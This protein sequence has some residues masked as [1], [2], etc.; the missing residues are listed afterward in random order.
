MTFWVDTES[1]THRAAKGRVRRALMPW[2]ERPFA[3]L[4]AG[5]GFVA[6]MLLAAFATI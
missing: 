1:R 3:W 6:L 2:Q 5:W 4:L